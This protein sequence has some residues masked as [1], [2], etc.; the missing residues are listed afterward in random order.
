MYHSPRPHE[1]R[2]SWART[3]TRSQLRTTRPE[4]PNDKPYKIEDLIQASKVPTVAT[5]PQEKKETPKQGM[6]RG[7]DGR[8]LWRYDVNGET[9]VRP[10]PV[11]QLTEEDYYKL[12]AN[13]SILSTGRLPQNLSVKFKEPQYVGY[14]FNKTARS[15]VRVQE[16]RS[17]GFEPA[18]R[19]DIETI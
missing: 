17:M 11:E 16:A 10:K 9:F 4:M 14:W 7:G 19:D 1:F 6:F 5:P 8:E 18:T 3:V 2:R 13:F 15:G 12:A